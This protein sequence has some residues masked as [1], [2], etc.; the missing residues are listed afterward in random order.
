MKGE[1]ESGMATDG[2]R[3]VG[4]CGFHGATW[5]A[6]AWKANLV[7]AFAIPLSPSLFRLATACGAREAGAYFPMNMTAKSYFDVD[8]HSKP[9]TKITAWLFMLGAL[10]HLMR[11]LFGWSVIVGTTMVPL[12]ASAIIIPVALVIAFLLMREAHS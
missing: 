9:M 7:P 11:L 1:G 2:M 3:L 12:W 10:I 4:Q 6:C 8:M 5:W